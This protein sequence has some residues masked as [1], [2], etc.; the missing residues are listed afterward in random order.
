MA[1]LALAGCSPHASGGGDSDVTDVQ[2][3]AE[4][5]ATDVALWLADRDAGAVLRVGA[6]DGQ[7]EVLAD[8]TQLGPLVLGEP[9]SVRRG[10]DDALYVTTYSPSGVTRMAE[11]DA[12]SFFSDS[13]LEEPVELAFRGDELFVLG[14]D[15]GNVV[16]VDADG[17]FVRELGYPEMRN[18]HDMAFGPDDLLYVATS[19]SVA[20]EGGV[21][22]WDVDA[23][24]LVDVLASEEEMGRATGLAFDEGGWLYVA[25]SMHGTVARFDPDGGSFEAIVAEGLDQ[26]VSLAVVGREMFVADRAGVHRFDVV[27]GE[28]LDSIVGSDQVERVRGVSLATVAQRR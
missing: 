19:Y 6:I 26:P 7:I 5:A 17:Q 2:A 15:T 21:Q 25:D 23:G 1:G 10:P 16:V 8:V 11:G 3:T 20:L 24:A 13:Y 4:P 12:Q 27:S 18:A 22:K 14:N 28:R 9:S